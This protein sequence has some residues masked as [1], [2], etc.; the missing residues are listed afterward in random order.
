MFS[1]NYLFALIRQSD[2]MS[3][4]VLL[5][6]CGMS[7]LCWTLFLHKL[8]SLRKRQK[9][10]HEAIDTMRQCDAIEQFLQYAV[11][12]HTTAAGIVMG[13]AAH[14]LRAVITHDMQGK[15]CIN[16]H[17]VKLVAEVLE[18]A[19]HDMMLAEEEYIPLFS[20]SATVAPL[21]GLFGTVWGLI[22]S[23]VRISQM[24]SADIVTVAPGIAEALIATLA[25]L[26]VAIPALFMYSYITS[27]V[28]YSENQMI[29]LIDRINWIVSR[30]V[31]CEG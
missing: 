22:H 31:H 16:S 3:L 23:F 29:A 8:F 9:Q 17:N 10:L 12:F 20:V 7:I 14:A 24:Q 2:L 18:Q 5:A 21:I 15:I 1:G 13:R 27:K 30:S 25:G 6:L 4:V 19:L 28:R 26:V 11:Q